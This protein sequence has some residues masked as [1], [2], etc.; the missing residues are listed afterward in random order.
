MR[1]SY[2]NRGKGVVNEGEPSNPPEST[3]PPL[4]EARIR[5]IIQQVM[6]ETQGRVVPPVQTPPVTP[7]E[8]G[9][10]VPPPVPNRVEPIYG[11]S[12]QHQPSEFKGTTDP[13]IAEEW[14]GSV[15]RA[16]G[17]FPMSD[18]EKIRYASFLFRGDAR[19]WWELMEETHDTT[20]MTWGEFRQEFEAEYR[21]ED[22]VH[23]KVQEFISLQQGSSTVKEYSV[24]FNSLARFAP[25]IVSTPA[26]R[27]D[28]FVH[29]LKPEIARDIMTSSD[30]PRTYSEA[31]RRAMKAEIFENKILPVGSSTGPIEPSSAPQRE[32]FE[33]VKSK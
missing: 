2:R 25:G 24:K 19:I 4:D 3:P 10:T 14:L 16:T 28:K 9:Q 20:V 31:L 8:R 29:G 21:T 33:G 1:R 11:L 32:K 5:G 18:R 27:R 15:E 6:A 30:P 17:L 23:E 12:S 26:L 22:Q 13:V 7:V